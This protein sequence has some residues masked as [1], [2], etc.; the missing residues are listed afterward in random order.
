LVDVPL[1]AAIEHR[2]GAPYLT[3]HRADLHAAL[4]NLCQGLNTVTLRP[5]FTLVSLDN[6]TDAVNVRSAEQEAISG[7]LLIGADGLW[8]KVRSVLAPEAEPRFAHATAFRTI[9]PREA[10]TG[11]FAEPIVGLW[12]GPRAHLVHYPVRS[13]EDLN[14]VAVTEGGSETE[15]W[16]AEANLAIL[17]SRFTDW[18]KDSKSLLE[19]ATSWRRWSLHRLRPL[20]H[21]S[22]R[23]VVLL[24]DAVHPTLPYLAQGAALAIEDAATL[25]Q[26]LAQASDLAWAFRRYQRA[27]QA[28]AARIQ[29]RSDLLGR[30]YHLKGPARSIRNALLAYRSPNALLA[31]LD[32]LYGKAPGQ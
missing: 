23:R 14:L 12:L 30:Y 24:G 31:S 6:R 1:G 19:F 18:C 8:S 20:R 10:L 16:D 7:D 27:R 11:R 9:L 4:L 3:L 2:Y 29:R 17:L 13:G 28:R 21:W 32:W 26:C 25:A 22:H 5:R 15:A